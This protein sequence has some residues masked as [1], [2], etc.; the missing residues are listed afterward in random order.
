MSDRPPHILSFG[1][2]NIDITARAERIPHPGETV[3]AASYATGL[4]GK[5]ANQA[6]A[7]ARLGQ[8][9]GLK[10]FMAG[11]TGADQFGTL[12]RS[13]LTP[14]G[15][16]L[17]ALKEDPAH[18]TGVALI[19][20]DAK[21]ENIITVAGG[22]NMA[23]DLSDV[24]AHRPLIHSASALLLQLEIPMAITIAVAEE[25]RRAGTLVVLDPAPAPGDGLPQALWQ[26]LDVV[27]PNETET[28][29]LTGI[30]PETEKEAA[31]AALKL[32]QLGATHALVKMGARGVYYRSGTE[33]GFVPPY[34]VKAIDTVAAGDCFN[35]GLTTALT[36]GKPFAEAVRYAAASGALA[37]TRLGAAESAPDWQDVVTL[38]ETGTIIDRN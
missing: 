22:A 25:A 34:T 1:S 6:A 24:E 32:H 20:V 14:F 2:V 10:V 31:Q 16:D 35:G 33:E 36:L 7:A 29:L 37:T 9:C 23:L 15:V 18:P 30:Y 28:R 27:T 11:R 26:A 5:G 3:H 17:S 4:G 13:L 19:T 21:A 8:G 38:V 12:A